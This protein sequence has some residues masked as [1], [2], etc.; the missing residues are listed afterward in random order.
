[1]TVVST[2]QLT[3]DFTPGLAERYAS[4]LDCVRAAAYSHR[5]PLKTISADMDMSQSELSRKLSGNPDDSRRFTLED[6][7]LFI[8]AT[9]DLSPIYYLVEKYLTDEDVKQRRALSELARQ[10]PEVLALIKAVSKG[11]A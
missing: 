2:S 1:M 10:L 5:N 3:L 4:A 8:T 11:S 7:E 9:G 6:L